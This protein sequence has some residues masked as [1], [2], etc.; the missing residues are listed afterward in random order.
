MPDNI[1]PEINV[2]PGQAIAG[3]LFMQAG[4]LA[5]DVYSAVNSSPW[6]AENFGADPSKAKSCREYVYHAIG[7]TF[8]Y[9]AIGSVLARS[10]WP[11]IGASVMSVYMYW[12]Y[13]RALMRGATTNATGWSQA[14][15]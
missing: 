15:N 1:I 7:L 6:T 4:T 11:I 5:M 3:L 10:W 9:S 14:G 13:N 12:L 2:G 8:F